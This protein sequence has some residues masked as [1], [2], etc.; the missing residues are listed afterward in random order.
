MRFSQWISNYFK[1]NVLFMVYFLSILLTKL[2]SQYLVFVNRFDQLAD[3]IMQHKCSTFKKIMQ[4]KY[5]IIKKELITPKINWLF[6]GKELIDYTAMEL[7]QRGLNKQNFCRANVNYR[8]VAT[9]EN[10]GLSYNGQ[11]TVFQVF[12]RWVGPARMFFT[13]VYCT[14]A[15]ITDIVVK[16]C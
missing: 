14:V 5:S 12:F 1:L 16:T 15:F 11:L 9:R 3:F 10:T 13:D 4:R 2:L 8:L 7:L 6:F